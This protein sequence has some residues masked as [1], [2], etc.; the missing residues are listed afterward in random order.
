MNIA[1]I[2]VGFIAFVNISAIVFICIHWS[3][4]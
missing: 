2:V 4:R 3:D 1:D